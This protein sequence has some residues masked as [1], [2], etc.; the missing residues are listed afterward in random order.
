MYEIEIM[1][2]TLSFSHA[3][4]KVMNVNKNGEVQFRP[5]QHKQISKCGIIDYSRQIFK[6]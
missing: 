2:R 3:V 6:D 5:E 1:T 4:K